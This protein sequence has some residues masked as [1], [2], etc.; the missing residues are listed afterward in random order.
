MNSGLSDS[1]TWAL[2]TTTLPKYLGEP[3]EDFGWPEEGGADLAWQGQQVKREAWMTAG[4]APRET[5]AGEGIPL[6]WRARAKA[7][8]HGIGCHVLVVYGW[9]ID[10]EDNLYFSL[11]PSPFWLRKPDCPHFPPS[12]SY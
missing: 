11:P 12:P 9:P 1:G 5:R 7:W 3:E 8:R 2:T 4:G 6:E 10:Q